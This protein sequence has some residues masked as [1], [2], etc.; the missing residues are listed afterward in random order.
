M[1]RQQLIENIEAMEKQG[2]KPDEI[3]SYINSV[4]SLSD[5]SQEPGI[6]KSVIQD[7]LNA[8]ARLAKTGFSVAE[9]LSTIRSTAIDMATAPFRGESA[10]DELVKGTKKLEEINKGTESDWGWFGGKVRPIGF[11]KD[12]DKL[13]AARTL[14]DAAG[15][16]AE[17]ASLALPFKASQ[18]AGFWRSVGQGIKSKPAL[19]FGLG[20]GLQA[21]AETG[22]IGEGLTTGAVDTIGSG[23]AFG[24]FNKGGQIAQRFGARLLASDTTQA[25]VQ[26]TKQLGEKIYG[27]I[28]E[29]LKSKGISVDDIKVSSEFKEAYRAFEND[30]NRSVYVNSNNLLQDARQ[31]Y[32]KNPGV[33]MTDLS[34]NI[35]REVNGFFNQARATFQA[36]DNADFN[37]SNFEN[38]LGKYKPSTVSVD[39]LINAAP[40]QKGAIE[41]F[42]RSGVEPADIARE[43]NISIE[44][45]GKFD[46]FMAKIMDNLRQGE[47]RASDVLRNAYQLIGIGDDVTVKRFTPEEQRVARSVGF[48]IFD[49]ME[50]EAMA[51]GR[52][53]VLNVLKKGRSEYYRAMNVAD[54]NTLNNMKTAGGLDNFISKLVDDTSDLTLDEKQ[55]LSKILVE[56]PTETEQLFVNSI[57]DRVQALIQPGRGQM[58]SPESLAEGSKFIDKFLEK[59]GV[60]SWADNIISPEVA[61]HLRLTSAFMKSDFDTA[62][63]KMKQMSDGMP[64][65][66]AMILDIIVKKGKLDIT[67]AI[68]KSDFNE[69]GDSLINILKKHGTEIQPYVAKLDDTQKQIAGLSLTHKLFEENKVLA[70]FDEQGNFSVDDT[71]KETLI[72]S[73]ADIKKIQL[74][75]GS[76][77]V[78]GLLDES[79][80]DG[81]D[82]MVQNISRE[83]MIQNL[84]PI[85]IQ[86]FIDFAMGSIYTYSRWFPG[87]QMRFQNALG[88]IADQ[89]AIK[90]LIRAEVERFGQKNTMMKIGDFLQIMAKFAPVP[91]Q[92]QETVTGDN[93]QE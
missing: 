13:N 49:D 53:D 43:L 69:F 56:N 5:S 57:L 66:E 44:T 36:A 73:A 38:S 34:R 54:S 88:E 62:L 83:R 7:T 89:A 77:T 41:S 92:T 35:G 72:K 6:V 61:E 65:T 63:S 27:T 40:G 64:E 24:I 10:L 75:S 87:A 15:V 11:G 90:E 52:E 23:I 74:A 70:L 32:S 84:E 55:I 26:E 78:F 39:D 2:A 82:R 31:A 20:T 45:G 58:P 8:P 79:V 51:A 46:S 42:A 29:A 67:E 80:V 85:T 59:R 68:K 48:Q 28:G 17:T 76:K 25:L 3:Q 1:N 93:Q 16:G 18:G 14:A 81:I 50:Q 37:F 47:L 86:P 91:T 19:A 71:F 4:G 12:G 33:I 9:G 22:S 30:F 21:T 60:F